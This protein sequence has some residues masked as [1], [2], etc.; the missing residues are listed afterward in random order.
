MLAEESSISEFID[1]LRNISTS[2]LA[3]H[4]QWPLIS[5]WLHGWP[6]RWRDSYHSGKHFMLMDSQCSVPFLIF[7]ASVLTT[8]RANVLVS[9]PP[10]SRT[11]DKTA[12]QDPGM[13]DAPGRAA[14]TPGGEVRYGRVGKPGAET[15]KARKLTP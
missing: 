8:R 1:A 9:C 6:G 3:P 14:H 11:C 15:P 5:L 2:L 7:G 4:L 10:D 13:L 12:R